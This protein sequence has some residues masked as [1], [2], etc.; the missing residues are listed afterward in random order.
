[1]GF[2]ELKVSECILWRIAHQ[3]KVG[4]W[5]NSNKKNCLVKLKTILR[6]FY[7]SFK[8]YNI[9]NIFIRGFAGNCYSE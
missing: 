5:L 4:E 8:W 3:V 6:Q 7:N 2:L 9:T 1:M